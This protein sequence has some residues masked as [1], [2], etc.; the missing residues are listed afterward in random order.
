M[1]ELAKAHRRMSPDEANY[2]RVVHYAAGALWTLGAT[3]Q[4]LAALWD[5]LIKAAG[6]QGLRAALASRDRDSG[7]Q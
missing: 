5:L 3:E 2:H 6:P 1:D 7:A 4:T